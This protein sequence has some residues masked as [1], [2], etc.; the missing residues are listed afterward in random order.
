MPILDPRID[1]YIAKSAEFAQPILTHLRAL[2]HASCPEVEET[3]KW[4]MPHFMYKGMLCNMAAFKQHCS[5]GFWKAEMLLSQA[6]T[7]TEEAMGQF[8]RIA[9]LKDLPPKKTLAGYI[10]KAMQLNEDGAK[11]PAKAKTAKPELQVQDYFLAA[12]EAQPA[13]LTH[14]D[15][16]STSK[17]RDYVEWLDEA[18][19]EATRLRRLEQAVEWI[20]EGKSR[21][22]KYEK[23]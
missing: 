14:F 5:F 11:A 1:A 13:A 9:S 19:T 16:F 4:G 12:L 22:W 21:N 10:K 15:A 3:V 18:K 8:G 23:C 17:K 6:D 7:K 2:V 20:A